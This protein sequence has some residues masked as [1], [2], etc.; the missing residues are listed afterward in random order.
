MSKIISQRE[1]KELFDE[2]V[3]KHHIKDVNKKYSFEKFL[4]YL[5]IDFYDWVKEN[6]RSYFRDI[7]NKEC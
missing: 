3:R 5:E 7:C 6:S 1:I 4:K 2:F